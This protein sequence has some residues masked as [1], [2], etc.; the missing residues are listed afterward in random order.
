M[1]YYPWVT[2][3]WTLTSDLVY[4]I[5]IESGAYLLYSLSRNSKLGV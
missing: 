5:G 1:A 2:V 3:T 4:R